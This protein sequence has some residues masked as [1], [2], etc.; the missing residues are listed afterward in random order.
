MSCAAIVFLT[1]P[2]AIIHAY[3]ADEDVLRVGTTLLAVAAAFQLF[4]GIQAA[5]TGALRGDPRRNG[6]SHVVENPLSFQRGT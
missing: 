4:D 3:T 5:A 6:A 1:A 2:G